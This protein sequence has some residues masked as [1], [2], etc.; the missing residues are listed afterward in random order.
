MQTTVRSIVLL[1]L[2]VLAISLSFSLSRKAGESLLSQKLANHVETV[3]EQKELIIKDVFADIRRAGSEG[4]KS[5]PWVVDKRL[6]DNDIVLF[7]F[8]GDS[9]MFWSHNSLP[10]API[11]PVT[12]NYGLH[13]IG[14]G[15]YIAYKDKFAGLDC[16]AL[17]LI[18]REYAYENRF[19]RNSW[20]KH[21]DLPPG[22]EFSV[23]ANG[24][25]VRGTDGGGLF[26][27]FEKKNRSFREAGALDYWSMGCFFMAIFLFLVLYRYIAKSDHVPYGLKA[28]LSILMPMILLAAFALSVRYRQPWSMYRTALFNPSYYALNDYLSSVGSVLFLSFVVFFFVYVLDKLLIPVMGRLSGRLFRMGFSGIAL[29]LYFVFLLLLMRSFVVNSVISF[30]A[31][32]LFEK[33]AFVFIFLAVLL[34]N[35]IGLTILFKNYTLHTQNISSRFIGDVWVITLTLLAYAVL[36][37]NEV[38]FPVFSWVFFIVL[39]ALFRYYRMEDL[40]ELRF[41]RLLALVFVFSLLTTYFTNHYVRKKESDRR[42]VLAVNLSE[43]HDPVAEMLLP[44]IDYQM[45]NDTVLKEI[46]NQPHDYYKVYNY[47]K[48]RYFS[49][50]W[51]KYD[52]QLTLCQPD[53]SVYVKPPEAKWYACYPFFKSLVEDFGLGMPD[54][55]FYYLN[56]G[57][58]RI[59]YFGRFV[60]RSNILRS[61]VTMF[62]ELD[63]RLNTE[64]LGYP[65]LLI[66]E[67]RSPNANLE[68]YGY[69][70]YHYDDL[71]SRTGDFAYPT[72][73]AGFGTIPAGEFARLK[74]DGYEHLFYRFSANGMIVISLP[75]QS[76]YSLVINF[77]YVFIFF[78]SVVSLLMLALSVPRLSQGHFSH[79]TSKIHISYSALVIVSLLSLTSVTIYLV[80]KQFREKSYELLREKMQSVYIEIDHKLAYQSNLDNWNGPGY[81]NL[82]Q[83]LV[84][85]SNV[86]YS[87]INLFGPDGRLL[88]TSRSEI[89]EK[90]LLGRR[91][92]YRAFYN[93]SALFKTEFMQEERI[94]NLRY[95]SAY[96][97]YYNV[98]G[99]L[100]AYLN[101]PY[102]TRQDD[103]RK[104]LIN[105]TIGIINIFVLFI[106]LAIITSITLSNQITK[107]L[108]LIQQK[109]RTMRLEGASNHIL[110]EANDEI[111]RLVKE[112]NKKVDELARS[113]RM[114][115]QNEREMAWR[116]MA[117]QVAHEIKN[118]LTPMR[119]SIQ[120]MLRMLQE[121]SPDVKPQV[122]KISRVLLDQIDNLSSIASAF[123]GFAS[124]PAGKD[125]PVDLVDCLRKLVTLFESHERV[126]VRF[127]S[128]VLSQ[129]MVLADSEQLSRAMLN[130]LT[131]AVQSIPPDREG[132]VSVKVSRT[133]DWYTVEI[134]DNGTGIP[135]DMHEKMFRPNFTTKS[136]GAGLG[137]AITRNIIRQYHG[138]IRFTTRQG[139][140]TSFF[141]ELP[142]LSLP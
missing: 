124:L 29:V 109:L 53:D 84:K 33:N 94:G 57:T 139:E 127:N 15:W 85:F 35:Y 122:E 92:D 7:V 54:S 135:A 39:Y 60:Y 129:A 99:K 42:M 120:H 10:F 30:Q 2:V 104:D 69:A 31:Y 21:F 51:N 12:F 89:F 73:L 62:V 90:Q 13:R 67:K 50:Y 8:R 22:I 11:L 142:V 123:S 75:I 25:L 118:P 41:A 98:E 65:E 28:P 32:N 103:L 3:I 125:E 119:L 46:F 37:Y 47:I 96:L 101:L 1:L 61:E 38:N 34:L 97:P 40:D 74:Y 66:E 9:L 4:F 136:S 140:G 116:E 128:G 141:V 121:G 100:L 138:D 20:Q 48:R 71:I 133:A 114:L 117:R 86:F 83:L 107:P 36:N 130:I 115:A 112:Y 79:I 76:F 17:M 26:Y 16:L 91:M 106:L 137:L 44:D 111:G 45:R 87:D 49:G 59:G 27:I 58:G 77:S 80:I 19:L 95:L 23:S 68:G 43:E 113:A 82:D 102:F 52:L 81:D 132:L 64:E 56:T 134:R 14:N 18:K 108:A 93:L 78:F 5:G 63:S 24:F 55:R 70:R 131:N 88:A 126:Q 6:T 110:Y 72:H 105:V